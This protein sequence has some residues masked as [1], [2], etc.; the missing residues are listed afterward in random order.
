MRYRFSC[1]LIMLVRFCPCSHALLMYAYPVTSFSAVV[2]AAASLALESSTDVF[3]WLVTPRLLVT[4]LI[5]PRV[6]SV[7]VAQGLTVCASVISGIMGHTAANFSLKSISPLVRRI[8]H[9]TKQKRSPFCFVLQVLSVAC[10]WEPVRTTQFF[11]R[12]AT[13]SRS[14]SRPQLI[15]SLYGW[16]AGANVDLAGGTT[17]SV[18]A[19]V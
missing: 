13:Y 3:G 6:T 8:L 7:T 15:G 19:F 17:S 14:T 16:A 5:P 10:L 11:S 9:T 12:H 1:I 2:C 4:F 18:L